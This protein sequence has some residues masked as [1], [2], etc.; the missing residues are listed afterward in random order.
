MNI[1]EEIVAIIFIVFLGCLWKAASYLTGTD[2]G[3]YA[4]LASIFTFVLLHKEGKE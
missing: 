2:I 3:I 1:R 4:G